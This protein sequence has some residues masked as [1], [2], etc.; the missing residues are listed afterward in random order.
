M[1]ETSNSE[2]AGIGSRE[3]RGCVLTALLILLV[4]GTIALFPWARG[5]TITHHPN[6]DGILVSIVVLFI[7]VILLIL[8]Y[9]IL[10][11]ARDVLRWIARAIVVFI[12]LAIVWLLLAAVWNW[13]FAPA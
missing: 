7:G 2:E 5:I 9:G 13:L 12:A 6:L 4:L 3:T 11:A 1:S 8:L 10:Y